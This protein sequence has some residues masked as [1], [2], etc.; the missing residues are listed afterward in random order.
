MEEY[1]WRLLL[2]TMEGKQ[3]ISLHQKETEEMA[4]SYSRTLGRVDSDRGLIETISRG[5][6]VYAHRSLW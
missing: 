1:L 3:R 5:V 2:S 6:C 4:E